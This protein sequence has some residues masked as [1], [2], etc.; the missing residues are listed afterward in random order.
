MDDDVSRRDLTPDPDLDPKLI[1]YSRRTQQDMVYA[2]PIYVEAWIMGTK[3]TLPTGWQVLPW[4]LN[5]CVTIRN[6]HNDI[7]KTIT[8]EG[9]EGGYTFK[10][11]DIA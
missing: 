8:Y 9:I 10:M 4:T 2:L 11:S 5:R 3:Q 6:S 1:E 7:M